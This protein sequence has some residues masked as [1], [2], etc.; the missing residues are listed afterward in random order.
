MVVIG[1]GSV[2]MTCNHVHP[3]RHTYSD[4]RVYGGAHGAV[5]AEVVYCVVAVRR[6]G[7]GREARFVND[8]PHTNCIHSGIIMS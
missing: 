2:T 5:W 6:S 4:S 3:I 1:L 7:R 8:E